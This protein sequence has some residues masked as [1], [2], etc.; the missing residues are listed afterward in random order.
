[1]LSIVRLTIRFFL[2]FIRNQN[3]RLSKISNVRLVYDFHDLEATILIYIP[4]IRHNTIATMLES[5]PTSKHKHNPN[6]RK[7]L[8]LN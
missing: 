7:M 3:V 6:F 1:M 5:R 2:E 4:I 8:M